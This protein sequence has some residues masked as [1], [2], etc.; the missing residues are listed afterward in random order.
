VRFYAVFKRGE[1]IARVLADTAVRAAWLCADRRGLDAGDYYVVPMESTP[2]L[3]RA[4]D[5][6]EWREGRLDLDAAAVRA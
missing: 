3:E 6:R 2:A 5:A 1:L 4:A